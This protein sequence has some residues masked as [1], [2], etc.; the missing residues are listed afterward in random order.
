MYI[1]KIFPKKNALKFILK[2]QEVMQ[3]GDVILTAAS[4][5]ASYGIRKITK[6]D[7]SHAILYVGNSFMH[8][9]LDGVHSGS[10]QRLLFESPS[11]VKVLRL[12]KQYLNHTTI[13]KIC[14]FARSENGKQYSKIDAARSIKSSNDKRIKNRQFCSRLV[15]QSFEYANINIVND[16]NYCTPHEISISDFFEE[17]IGVVRLAETEDINFANSHSPLDLQKDITNNLLN[18]IRTL[19][20]KDIQTLNEIDRFLVQNQSFDTV[21]NEI[22]KNS[23]YLELWKIDYEKN[24]WR[25]DGTIFLTFNNEKELI[26][27][28]KRTGEQ[29]LDYHDL[30]KAMAIGERNLFSGRT[31]STNQALQFNSLYNAYKEYYIQYNLNYFLT[32]SK[33]YELLLENCKKRIDAA[34]Y[35]LRHYEVIE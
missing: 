12:K 11:H 4:T 2:F 24:P 13:E 30:R 14:T 32:L 6:S 10:P 18:D 1:H 21:I 29:Y 9:D 16:P 20:G 28:K 7:F 22:L 8:S 5:A 31:I 35:V 33:L 26:K 34:E 15:A 27:L 17:V 23:G 25:Y 19:T 3:P